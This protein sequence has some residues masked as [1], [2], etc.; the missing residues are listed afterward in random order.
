MAKAAKVKKLPTA[1]PAEPE[2]PKKLVFYALPEKAYLEILAYLGKLSYEQVGNLIPFIRGNA[3]KL[4]TDPV[5]DKKQE[6]KKEDAPAEN[7][8]TN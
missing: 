7:T 2:V 8:S 3:R 1:K 4:E 6:E 5:E